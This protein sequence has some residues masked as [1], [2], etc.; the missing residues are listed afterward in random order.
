MK[1]AVKHAMHTAVAGFGIPRLLHKK[2][3]W[4]EVTILMYHAVVRSPLKIGHECFLSEDLFRTQ[5]SYLKKHFEVI[6]LSDAIRRMQDGL[7]HRPT[8][9]ITFD[10]GFQNNY[11]I[12]FPILRSEDLPATVFLCTGC[13]DTN[14][15]LWFC[16]LNRAMTNTTLTSLEWSGSR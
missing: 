16:H 11:D 5:M 14:S 12:C 6:H 13:I 4:N 2:V 9:V 15:T 3:F 8:A 1:S 10:D 7:I